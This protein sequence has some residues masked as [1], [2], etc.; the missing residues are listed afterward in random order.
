M[1]IISA[2]IGTQL[3]CSGLNCYHFSG[4]PLHIGSSV[5]LDA[6]EHDQTVCMYQQITSYV[7]R[8]N[9]KKLG[10]FK[11]KI[12]FSPDSCIKM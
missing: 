9:N 5:R 8:G 12:L 2:F 10:L 11:I 6:C 4:N 3:G 7:G 1:R